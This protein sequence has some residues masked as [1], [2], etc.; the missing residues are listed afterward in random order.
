MTKFVPINV[1]LLGGVLSL[2]VSASSAQMAG[3]SRPNFAGN[4]WLNQGTFGGG[5]LLP[6]PGTPPEFLFH[7]HIDARKNGMRG[8]HSTWGCGNV[9]QRRGGERGNLTTQLGDI[10]FAVGVNAVAEKDHE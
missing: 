5:A 3:Q 9:E 1:L 10:A 2:L 7:Q 4:G 6:A 8:S